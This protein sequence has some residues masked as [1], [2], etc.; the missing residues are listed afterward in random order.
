M[1]VELWKDELIFRHGFSSFRDLRKS[2][3]R[4]LAPPP[5]AVSRQSTIVPPGYTLPSDFDIPLH[6]RKPG[7]SF[8]GGNE[9]GSR[10]SWIPWQGKT[11]RKLVQMQQMQ[12]FRLT[13]LK[14]APS[15]ISTLTMEEY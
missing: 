15:P 5:T 4:S 9:I 7:P 10:E 2:K 3:S 13:N 14:R 1:S 8:R 12:R 6:T 11:A